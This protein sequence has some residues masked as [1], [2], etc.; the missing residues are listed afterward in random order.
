M[1]SQ[2][3]CLSND[4][5]DKPW[6]LGIVESWYRYFDFATSEDCFFLILLASSY[7]PFPSDSRNISGLERGTGAVGSNGK[8]S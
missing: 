3:V 5:D 4:E 7:M 8:L 6:C 1:S 2:Q